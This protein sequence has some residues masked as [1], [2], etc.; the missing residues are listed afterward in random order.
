MHVYSGVDPTVPDGAYSKESEHRIA[1]TDTYSE[2]LEGL[3]GEVKLNRCYKIV[4]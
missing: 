4:Q 1:A 2:F 3:N